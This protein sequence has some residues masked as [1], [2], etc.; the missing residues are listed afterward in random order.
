MSLTTDL[1]PDIFKM[2]TANEGF[3]SLGTD[4][5]VGEKVK[6]I[7][8]NEELIA[9]VTDVSKK[10]FRVDQ[11][12]DGEVFVYGRQVDDFRTIDYEAISMLNV[13]ATQES[14]K[15][16]KSLEQQNAKLKETCE[17][18]LDLKS[19]LENLKKSVSMLINE[20]STASTEKK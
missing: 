4:L 14:L 5:I 12:E 10:G 1:I 15:R 11:C 17:E 3:I 13:S 19:E 18:L 7:F 8:E 6:L 16:I 20:K 9:T 2:A